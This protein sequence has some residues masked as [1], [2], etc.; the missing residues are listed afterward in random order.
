M[1]QTPAITA[2][3]N[4]G[5]SGENSGRKNTYH[6]ATI[7]LQPLPIVSPGETQDVKTQDTGPR[8]LRGISKE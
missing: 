3:M 7:R 5:E 4:D 2:T 6:L 8:Q 1:S